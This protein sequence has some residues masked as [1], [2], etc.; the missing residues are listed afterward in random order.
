MD[1]AVLFVIAIASGVAVLV[2]AGFRAARKSGIERN[3]R[4]REM[5][6]RLGLEYFEKPASVGF[7]PPTPIVTGDFGGRRAQVHEFTRGSGKNRTYWVAARLQCSGGGSLKLS[8]RTQGSALYEKLAGM[9]GY[10]DI[11]VGDRAFDSVFSISGSDEEFIKAAL[12]P[13]IRA[14]L[15]AFWPGA[16]GGRIRVEDGEAVYEEMGNLAKERCR[17]NVEKSLPVL[18]DMAAIAEVHGR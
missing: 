10:K 13:E 14:R 16:R 5:A 18:A 2:V 1:A 7:L 15:V 9:F 3:A 17:A 12:I 4:L 11:D 8:L 6:A